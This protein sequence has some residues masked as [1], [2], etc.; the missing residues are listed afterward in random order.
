MT[1]GNDATTTAERFGTAAAFFWN[2][3]PYEQSVLRAV[4]KIVQRRCAMWDNPRTEK[5]FF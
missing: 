2:S 3:V 5:N 1:A 4:A